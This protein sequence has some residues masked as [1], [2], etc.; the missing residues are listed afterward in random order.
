MDKITAEEIILA[1]ELKPL[2]GEGG[3]FNQ[4]YISTEI[5]KCENLPERYPEKKPFSTAIYFFLTSEPDSFSAMH[6]LP[7]DEIYHFYLGD[8]V[9]LVELH[10]DGNGIETLIISIAI[11]K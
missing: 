6:K 11:M 10:P 3:L 7:T 8:P 2:V 4:T 9:K 1:L 5:L